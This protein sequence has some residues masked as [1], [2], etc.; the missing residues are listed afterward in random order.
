M[1]IEEEDSKQ[2]S[3]SADTEILND[4]RK[5]DISAYFISQ[6][7]KINQEKKD[8]SPRRKA[9]NVGHKQNKNGGG[10]SVRIPSCKVKNTG[11]FVCGECNKK[12]SGK[13][14]VSGLKHIYKKDGVTTELFLCRDS[15]PVNT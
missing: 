13:Y 11:K 6:S 8:S 12:F 10:S 15:L 7:V 3:S 9:T 14:L 2:R 4:L 5:K 1:D